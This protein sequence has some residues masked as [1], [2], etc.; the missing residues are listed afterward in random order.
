MIRMACPD[1]PKSKKAGQAKSKIKSMLIMFF[2]SKGIF[3]KEFVLAGQTVNS[4]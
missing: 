3:H 2:D 1:T 4:A